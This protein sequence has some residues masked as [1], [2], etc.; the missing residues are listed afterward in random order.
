MS[1]IVHKMNREKIGKKV[2]SKRL[3]LK[4]S[5][6]ELAKRSG[7]TIQQLHAIEDS[8]K[9]YRVDTLLKILPVLELE[10]SI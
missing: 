9:S 3:L 1:H 10:L 6:Y 8:T 2:K 4:M 5:Y 7:V